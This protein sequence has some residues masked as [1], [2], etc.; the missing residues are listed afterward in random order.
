MSEQTSGDKAKEAETKV[1]EKITKILK[2]ENCILLPRVMIVGSQ[3]STVVNVV[4]Q[5]PESDVIT[6]NKK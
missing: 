2:D 6:P 5:E 3:I 1:L 4:Y